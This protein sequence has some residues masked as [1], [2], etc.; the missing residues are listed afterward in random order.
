MIDIGS[1]IVSIMINEM[2]FLSVP[3]SIIRMSYQ[4]SIIP[5]RNFGAVDFLY[6]SYLMII[7]V[8]NFMLTKNLCV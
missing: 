4:G 7:M 8:Q 3:S 1:L 6:L 5:T 2:H